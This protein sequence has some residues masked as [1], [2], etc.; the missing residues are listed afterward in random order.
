MKAI[1]ELNKK[2]LK[3]VPEMKPGDTVCVHIKI[4]EGNKERIQIFEGVVLRIK[5]SGIGATFTVR[6]ISYGIGVER[7]FLLHSP[8]I[9]KIEI[10]KRAKVRKAFISYLRNLSGKATKL[11]DKQFDALKVNVKEEELK[12]EDLAPPAEVNNDELNSEITEIDEQATDVKETEIS[13]EELAEQE[14]RES[15]K[16]EK[17]ELNANLDENLTS[18]EEIEQGI[19]ESE[20]DLEN[21]ADNEG[22][23]AEKNTE[24]LEG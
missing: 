19:K 18:N 4:I 20:K 17:E 3:K 21:G 13:T 23:L 6:K 7:I 14:M 9:T 1:E 15:N 8:K 11:K 2:Q 12:P 5:G 24:E 16:I 10:K 22:R